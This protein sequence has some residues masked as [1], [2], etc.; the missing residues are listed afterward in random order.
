MINK[1][2][3]NMLQYLVHNT[4]SLF[5]FTDEVSGEASSSLMSVPTENAE[6]CSGKQWLKIN[7]SLDYKYKPCL[8]CNLEKEAFMPAMGY[9]IPFTDLSLYESLTKMN[10]VFES[11][12]NLSVRHGMYKQGLSKLS[13]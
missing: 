3:K 2:L 8:V 12:M 5:L 4:V 6:E 13:R 10:R 1:P 11:L 7:V 9:L